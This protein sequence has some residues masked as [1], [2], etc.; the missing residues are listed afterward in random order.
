MSPAKPNVIFSTSTKENFEWL[1]GFSD[2]SDDEVEALRCDCRWALWSLDRECQR[3]RGGEAEN[4]ASS[5]L[6][7]TIEQNAASIYETKKLNP[8]Q[9]K[10]LS[11]SSAYLKSLTS[12]LRI[13]KSERR[14][15]RM[16]RELCWQVSRWTNM[17]L[18]RLL[19]ASLGRSQLNG[20]YAPKAIQ[21][22]EYLY[23]HRTDLTRRVCG[24]VWENGE[25]EGKIT[26]VLQSGKLYLLHSSVPSK[27]WQALP[28]S[29]P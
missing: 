2:V 25:E 3:R 23:Q 1:D 8:D 27:S 11:K 26:S 14:D 10:K 13:S 4:A 29:S 20:F 17:D 7:T 19:V 21:A 22:I 9:K 12:T 24:V 28:R 15:Q 6:G 16:C 18:T 5:T